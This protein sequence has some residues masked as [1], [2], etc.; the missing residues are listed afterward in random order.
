MD[1]VRCKWKRD[2]LER[3]PRSLTLAVR[4][5]VVILSESFNYIEA[6][7]KSG[8][9]VETPCAVWWMNDHA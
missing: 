8:E 4:T 9:K 7:L 2:G 3:L 6:K 5:L 1:M